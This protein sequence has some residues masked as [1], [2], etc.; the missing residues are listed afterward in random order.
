[1]K[2][3]ERIKRIPPYI[4]A[5]ID[6]KK[7]EAQ[8]RGIDIIDLGIGDPDLPTPDFII[9]KMI[10]AVKN[11]KI[12]TTHPIKGL[13]RFVKRLCVGI[14]NDLAFLWMQTKKSCL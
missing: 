2:Q 13:L 4:F 6:E 9:D 1:M 10:E 7:A 11:L 12:I 3:V 8:S 14:K 5:Q